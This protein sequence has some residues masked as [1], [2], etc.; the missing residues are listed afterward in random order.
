[1][2]VIDESPDRKGPR[3]KRAK[4][5]QES[6]R[7]KLSKRAEESTDKPK[8]TQKAKSKKPSPKPPV[9]VEPGRVHELIAAMGLMG[10]K[11]LAER[12]GI[13]LNLGK[14]KKVE[15]YLSTASEGEGSDPVE[16]A[17]RL[18]AHIA[19]R[20]PFVKTIGRK[21]EG[22]DKKSGIFGDLL[23]FGAQVASRNEDLIKEQ[24]AEMFANF[25]S[26]GNKKSNSDSDS[27]VEFGP[28]SPIFIPDVDNQS[29]G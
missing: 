8:A 7:R 10:I 12:Q 22:T 27:Y 14:V 19:H 1:M 29:G 23:A 4:A 2:S 20:L 13:E 28:V 21:F 11:T 6:A 18:V 25:V 15:E 16:I 5:R 26:N 17:S 9:R 3:S 24:G